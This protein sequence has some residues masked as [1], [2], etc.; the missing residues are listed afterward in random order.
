MMR[1]YAAA[2]PNM[3]LQSN[4]LLVGISNSCVLE[5]CINCM[6]ACH[7]S[8]KS[9][10]VPL[11]VVFF[12][13]QICNAIWCLTVQSVWIFRPLVDFSWNNYKVTRRCTIIWTF[14]LEDFKRVLWLSFSQIFASYSKNACFSGF[15]LFLQTKACIVH[16]L[17]VS[18]LRRTSM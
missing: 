14:F 7:N 1:L 17:S 8:S 11:E 6:Q 2:P 12:S 18:Y 9:S 10:G 13:V 15:S 3:R 16:T 4:N 5:W